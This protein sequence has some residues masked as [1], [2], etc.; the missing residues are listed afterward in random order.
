MNGLSCS[1]KYNKVVGSSQT[2]DRTHIPLVGRRIL[3]HCATREVL[4]PFLSLCVELLCCTLQS[5]PSSLL[6]DFLLR[7]GR[8]FNG[9]FLFDITAQSQLLF[10]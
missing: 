8:G 7:K 4:V 2:R 10:K 5:L 6:V 3:I 9:H 1:E